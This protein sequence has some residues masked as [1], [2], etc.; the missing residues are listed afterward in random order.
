MAVSIPLRCSSIYYPIS[1]LLIYILTYI[2]KFIKAI[3]ILYCEHL[4]FIKQCFEI[5]LLLIS[6]LVFNIQVNIMLK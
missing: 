4:T 6:V 1:S 5:I 3:I 2:R